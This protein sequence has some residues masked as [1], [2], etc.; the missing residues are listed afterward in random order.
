[1]L[2]LQRPTEWNLI[3]NWCEFLGL[4]VTHTP[5]KRK[6]V[7]I[8]ARSWDTNPWEFPGCRS[9]LMTR[10]D[11]M[12]HYH[13]CL[14]QVISREDNRETEQWP[15]TFLKAHCSYSLKFFVVKITWGIALSLSNCSLLGSHQALHKGLSTQRVWQGACADVRDQSKV[16][17]LDWFDSRSVRRSFFRGLLYRRCVLLLLNFAIL[18]RSLHVSVSLAY[19]QCSSGTSACKVSVANS[20]IVGVHECPFGTKAAAA[21]LLDHVTP[22][23]VTLSSRLTPPASHT[24]Q[25]SAL[26]TLEWCSTQP[27]I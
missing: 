21:N 9:V 23:T 7:L 13:D 16:T 19:L 11:Y 14:L 4:S 8:A 18:R 10:I 15:D 20:L 6:I 3:I 2:L 12:T 5:G 22:L 26:V 17:L 27:V 25:Y 1:M 24:R